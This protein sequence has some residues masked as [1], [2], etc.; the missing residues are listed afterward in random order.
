[1]HTSGKDIKE[2][3][4]LEAGIRIKQK[5]KIIDNI[6]YV[7]ATVDSAAI[8]FQ[9]KTTH[10]KE[11]VISKFKESIKEV[12]KTESETISKKTVYRLPWWLWAAI[13]CAAG[14]IVFKYFFPLLK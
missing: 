10:I 14:F 12:E 11:V 9:Y 6:V 5:I 13:A 3:K 7:T 8:Y 2:I 4:E 1:M